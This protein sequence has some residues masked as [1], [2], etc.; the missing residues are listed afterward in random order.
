MD[1]TNL[2]HFVSRTNP[3][4]VMKPVVK[5]WC[6]G[7]DEESS[8]LDCGDLMKADPNY[9]A[10]VREFEIY[11]PGESN[12]TL[13]SSK[14]NVLCDE[15]GWTVFQARGQVGNGRNYFLRNWESYRRGFG[16]PGEKVRVDDRVFLS[17]RHNF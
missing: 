11:N 8:L 12:A 9:S 15:E 17:L 10:G 7:Q 4:S 3:R 2:F 6:P 14:V 13:T 16:E 1:H 5:K